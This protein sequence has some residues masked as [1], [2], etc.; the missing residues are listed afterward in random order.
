M[1]FTSVKAKLGVTE[2][3]QSSPNQIITLF[4]TKN[5]SKDIDILII[6]V[7]I[8]CLSHLPIDLHQERH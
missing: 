7:P 2:L 6:V 1:I 3:L 8:Y 4:L 5:I